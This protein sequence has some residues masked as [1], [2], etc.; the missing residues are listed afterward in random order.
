MIFRDITD[1]TKQ[2]DY[3][4]QSKTYLTGVLNNLTETILIADDEGR[5][6]DMN[7]ASSALL[8]YSREELLNLSIYNITADLN[9]E[10]VK[11][12]D[13]GE[14]HNPHVNYEPSMARG[15]AAPRNNR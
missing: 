6:V 2:S 3:L 12:K 7:P 10:T 11:E 4:Q 8:G 15:V 13:F 14:H 9:H 1:R 5:Y